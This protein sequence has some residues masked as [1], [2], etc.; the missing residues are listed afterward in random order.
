MEIAMSACNSNARTELKKPYNKGMV[1]KLMRFGLSFKEATASSPLCTPFVSLVRNWSAYMLVILSLFANMSVGSGSEPPARKYSNAERL[2]LVRLAAVHEDVEKLKSHRINIPLLPGLNDYRCILHAHAEDSAHTGGTLAEMLADAKKAGI[3]AILLSDHF[4]PPRDF[5]DG[6][7]RG[8]KE[9]VL[10]IPG[11]ETNGFLVYPVNSILKRMDLKGMDFIN[12]VTSG[13]GLIFL[14]HIEERK[15]HPMDGLTGL[16]IYNRHWDAIQDKTMLLVLAQK[17]TDPKQLA[18]L[19]EGVR[20]YPDELFAFQCDYPRL[21]LEKWDEGTKHQ[22]LTGIA[23]NDCHHNQVLIVKMVDENTVLLGANVDE[24]A[25]MQKV[26]AGLR[27][28]IKEMTKGHKPGDI[29]AK[30]DTDPY[31]RSFRNSTTHILA[32]KLKED[33]IRTALKAGHAFVAHDWMCDTTGFRFTATDMNDMVAAIMG[34]EVKLADGMK[35]AAKLPL[36]AH[37]RLTRDGKE[38][39]KSEGKAEFE[40]AVKEAGVYRLEA[41]LKLDGELRPWIFGNPIYVR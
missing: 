27:P 33:T 40:F 22:R 16:E 10:F 15:D 18:E 13:D 6:R 31:F 25:K 1:D 20:L 12:T 8:L 5:I 28:G 30:L 38:V 23:A 4:R 37:V 17:L 32:P 29:L 11:S 7:W 9:G 41:W 34:D 35:L 24:D 19:Q 36:P 39:A 2:A 14:S 26:T 3:S 21:Y